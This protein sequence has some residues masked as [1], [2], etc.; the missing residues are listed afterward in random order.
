NSAVLKCMVMVAVCMQLLLIGSGCCN[1]CTNIK[2]VKT[3]AETIDA[4]K[5]DQMEQL[6]V[7][8]LTG[9]HSFDEK[10]FYKMFAGYRLIEPT[11]IVGSMSL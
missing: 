6:Q 5:T 10:P 1:E 2:E 4:N 3:K 11:F 9:G 7:L 8:V